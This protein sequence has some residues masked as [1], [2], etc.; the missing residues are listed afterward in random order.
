MLFAQ[1]GQTAALFKGLNGSEFTALFDLQNLSVFSSCDLTSPEL[2][3]CTAT[4]KPPTAPCFISC[5]SGHCLGLLRTH[6]HFSQF[7]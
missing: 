3:L 5:V 4:P 6:H 7:F 2:P 1:G